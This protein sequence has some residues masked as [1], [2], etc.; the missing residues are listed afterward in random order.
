MREGLQNEQLVS[1]YGR[2]A[3]RYDLQ[4]GLITARS[5]QRGREAL[6]ERAVGVGT[7]V[8][9]CG[10]GTGSTGLLAARKVGSGGHVTF[11]DLSEDMLAVA[12]EKVARESLTD[13]AAFECGDMT[14]LPFE[15]NSFDV[16]VSSY[17]LC[18][19]YNPTLGALEMYR[20]VKPGGKV[21]IAHSAEPPNRFVRAVADAVESVAWKITTLSMGC[22]SIEVLPA[23]QKAG[24][25]ITYQKYFGIPLWPFFIF[26]V[27]KPAA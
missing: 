23:F 18:P 19:V 24:G 27:E 25:R 10:A 20:V 3:K 13:R 1:I 16:V 12:K 5:D 22:R 8:L 15:D 4:H 7:K 14:K 6:V 2:I 26:V 11:F 21:G 9:D 17:S